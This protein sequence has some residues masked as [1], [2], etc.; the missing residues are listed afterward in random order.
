[1]IRTH[2]ILDGL[3]EP[4][5]AKALSAAWSKAGFDNA[6]DVAGQAG[7]LSRA[8]SPDAALTEREVD[9]A[10]SHARRFGVELRDRVGNT[11]KPDNELKLLRDRMAYEYK[12]RFATALVFGLPALALHYLGPILAGAQVSAR[13]MTYPWLIELLL[14]GWMCLAAGWPI[15]WQGTLAMRHGRIT[16]DLFVTLTVAAAWLPSAA[17]VAS[18]A[19]IKQPWLAPPGEGIGPQFHVANVAITIAV[20]QRWLVW[21]RIEALAGRA[22]FMLRH[23]WLFILIWI[24]VSVAVGVARGWPAGLA[25]ALL[26]PPTL[27]LGGISPLTPGW[28]VAFPIIAF[29][30]VV[31]AQPAMMGR[32]L[33]PVQTEVAAGFALV[34]SIAL[35]MGWWAI[36]RQ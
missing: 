12:S 28:L 32:D 10:A 27:S 20:L 13:D 33:A 35:A 3:Q 26:L 8:Q 16:F 15:L 1:M 18:M 25:F 7:W 34:M 6:V 17:G 11:F 14:V 23:S 29:A 9:V 19:F 36:R 31:L 22:D 5:D 2:V 21:R 30:V 4:D 24:V